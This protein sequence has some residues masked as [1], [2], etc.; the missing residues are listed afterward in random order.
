ML[1]GTTLLPM[2]SRCGCDEDGEPDE[3]DGAEP[4]EGDDESESEYSCESQITNFLSFSL[5]DN[6]R[7]NLHVIERGHVLVFIGKIS[8]ILTLVWPKSPLHSSLHVLKNSETLPKIPHTN[9]SVLS[10]HTKKEF[11]FGIFLS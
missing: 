3:L 6:V 11:N 8:H 10:I 9:C 7:S 1:G 5:T 4:N 2:C